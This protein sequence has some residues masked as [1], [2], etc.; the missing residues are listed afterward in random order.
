MSHPSSTM[1]DYIPNIY[2]FL[3]SHF[4]G[5]NVITKGLS[6]ASILYLLR[7]PTFDTFTKRLFFFTI[8][9]TF[10][11]LNFNLNLDRESV[12]KELTPGLSRII[13]LGTCYVICKKT[14]SAFSPY[15]CALVLRIAPLGLFHFWYGVYLSLKWILANAKDQQQNIFLPSGKNFKTKEITDFQ[16]TTCCICLEANCNYLTNCEHFFHKECL[17]KWIVHKDKCPLCN[18]N[19]QCRYSSLRQLQ[20][21]FILD[22]H[23]FRNRLAGRNSA[24]G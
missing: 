4:S 23:E 13:I 17:E 15:L 19:L 9:G 2:G 14:P 21:Y 16:E 7:Y 10:L 24:M 8:L 1:S 5:T 20:K 11:V 22:Y 18:S 3:I 12:A 6:L